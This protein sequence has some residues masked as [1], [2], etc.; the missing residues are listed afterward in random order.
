MTTTV[1][2]VKF[3]AEPDVIYGMQNG[4]VLAIVVNVKFDLVKKG[5]IVFCCLE[6][7]PIY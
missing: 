5:K 1:A 2:L 7:L 6:Q 4:N 3:N